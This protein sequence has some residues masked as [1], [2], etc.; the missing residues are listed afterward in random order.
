MSWS[1]KSDEGIYVT[2]VCKNYPVSFETYVYVEGHESVKLLL[3]HFSRFQR[4]AAAVNVC[5]RM[6]VKQS[7]SDEEELWAF[8]GGRGLIKS[9]SQ[10]Y[11][12]WNLPSKGWCVCE[13]YYRPPLRF[14]HLSGLVEFGFWFGI[15]IFINIFV[16][17]EHANTRGMKVITMG[18]WL[19]GKRFDFYKSACYSRQQGALYYLACI[20]P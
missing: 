16:F 3:V 17:P 6:S 5:N 9:N 7:V 10:S 19:E 14:N 8:S 1:M 13:C 15:C 11:F 12:V 20:L 18:A 2:S 4:T